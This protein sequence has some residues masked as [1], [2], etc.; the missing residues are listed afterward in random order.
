MYALGTAVSFSYTLTGFD[1]SVT[2]SWM[3]TFCLG[4]GSGS[5]HGTV[6][7][8]PASSVAWGQMP[9]LRCPLGW[10]SGGCLG[11]INQKEAQQVVAAC[12]Q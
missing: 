4:A 1:I 10:F 5:C 3:V 11:L 9:D 7:E 2:G 6:F 12:D 8:F